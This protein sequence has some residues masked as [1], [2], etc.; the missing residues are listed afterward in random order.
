MLWKSLW[1]IDQKLKLPTV[2]DWFTVISGNYEYTS[3]CVCACLS[4][5]KHHIRPSIKYYIHSSAKVNWLIAGA[6]AYW[7]NTCQALHF[8]MAHT[9]AKQF[10]RITKS[11]KK[12]SDQPQ[13]HSAAWKRGRRCSQSEKRLHSATRRARSAATDGLT[14]TEHWSQ[15]HKVSVVS[16]EETEE[17][18]TAENHRR[19][20]SPRCFQHP[21]VFYEERFLFNQCGLIVNFEFLTHSHLFLP[22]VATRCWILLTLCVL[23][24]V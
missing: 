12:S 13:I 9:S 18:N 22:F 2:I 7:C 1:I 21:P 15:H 17:T 3:V 24:C 6:V 20:T 5:W 4:Q 11:I 16:H 19:I 10:L 23:Y 14:P 8:R